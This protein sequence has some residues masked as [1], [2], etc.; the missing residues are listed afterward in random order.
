MQ[1]P[2]LP[3]EVEQHLRNIVQELAKRHGM[4]RLPEV[5]CHKRGAT[6]PMTSTPAVTAQTEIR[7]DWQLSITV[8]MVLRG[9]GGDPN[10]V[11]QRQ[12]RLV[13]LAEKRLPRAH[14]GCVLKLPLAF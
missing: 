1:R 12:P 14:P 3:P 10:N 11:R 8:D 13:A 9:Q 4:E 2:E 5:E 6:L 7:T